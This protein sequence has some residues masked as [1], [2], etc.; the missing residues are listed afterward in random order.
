MRC[1]Q[2]GWGQEDN[3]DGRPCIA[4]GAATLDEGL[5]PPPDKPELAVLE[6]EEYEKDNSQTEVVV[7]EQGETDQQFNKQE[8]ESSRP[9]HPGFSNTHPQ[10]NAN[11]N[12]GNGTTTQIERSVKQDLDGSKTGGDRSGEGTNETGVG[13]SKK[14]GKKVDVSRGNASTT[15]STSKRASSKR[16]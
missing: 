1:V 13:S 3:H 7:H 4:C 2:C 15:G 11:P 12:R 5:P 10:G 8:I 16:R 9:N 6:R 14:T